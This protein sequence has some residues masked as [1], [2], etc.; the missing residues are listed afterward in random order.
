MSIKIRASQA[1][2]LLTPPRGKK[3]VDKD[4][5]LSKTAMSYIESIFDEAHGCVEPVFTPVLAKGLM[6]EQDAF[7]LISKKFPAQTFRKKNETNFQTDF[8]TGTPDIVLT[9]DEIIE[10]AKCSW[11]L[12][13]FRKAELTRLY[14]TQCQVYMNV[15]SEQLGGK[16]HNSRLLF[17]LVNTPEVLVVEEEK[18]FFFKYGCDDQNPDY[19]KAC[20]NIRSS[21]NFD[22]IPEEKKCKGF[23]FDYDEALIDL[24][25]YKVDQAREYYDTLEI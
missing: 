15:V 3:S 2:T 14:H 6:C 20:K 5:P 11:T 16:F 10:D 22:H 17:C 4:T 7:S 1:G 12:K 19:I 13:T 9:K 25:K 21:H 24:L 8:F 18:R 23:V